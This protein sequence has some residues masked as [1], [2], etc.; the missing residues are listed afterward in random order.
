[1]R[2]V[3]RVSRVYYE[4]HAKRMNHPEYR[5]QGFPLTSSLVESAVKQ[6]GRR[7]KGS[8]KYWS[9]TGGEA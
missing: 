2:E 7:V 6:V 5:R 4:N 3:V 8:E 1:P 9:C